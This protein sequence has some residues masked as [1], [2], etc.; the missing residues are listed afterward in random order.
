MPD[1]ATQRAQ[2]ITGGIEIL[3]N[4]EVD[5][6]KALAEVPSLAI[7]PTPS[8]EILYVTLD[9]AGRSANKAMADVRVRKA[10]FMA[11][12][13]E[14]IVKHFVPGGAEA[15][16]P[17]AICFKETIACKPTNKPWGYDPAQAKKLL[18][19]AGYA[20]GLDL[21]LTC[22]EPSRQMAE[23]LAGELRKVG[24]RAT[25]RPL[26]AGLR[27]KMRGDGQLTA[28]FAFYP[29][30]ADPDTA[31]VLS[32]FFGDDR[33]YTNDPAI[34]KAWAAG[35]KEFDVAKRSAIYTPVLDRINE[36]AY[37][38]PLSEMPIVYAHSKNVT[39]L[40]NQLSQ[41]EIR[42]GDFAWAK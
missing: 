18:V 39:L 27:H 2:L 5:D 15:E 12:N 20:E 29:T 3:R 1:R 31:N 13:R 28:F 30:S 7:T 40:P 14:E 37:V 38:F 6:A 26:D 41:G 8:G 9:A 11:I 10:F 36:Q 17:D 42:V 22:A 35:E 21:E 32:F 4:V 25:V 24:F 34:A 16:I 33:D 19:D 23:A